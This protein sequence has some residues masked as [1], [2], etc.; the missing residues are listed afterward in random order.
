MASATGDALSGQRG[1]P[2][3]GACPALPVGC[4]PTAAVARREGKTLMRRRPSTAAGITALAALG[5]ATGI[6]LSG[7]DALAQGRPLSIE[8]DSRS[9]IQNCEGRDVV[10]R[11]NANALRFTGGCRSVTV[12][13]NGNSILAEMAPGGRIE[14]VGNDT[15]VGWVPAGGG[16]QARE[17]TVSV[18]GRDSRVE[19]AAAAAGGGAPAQPPGGPLVLEGNGQQRS[20]DC[21][22]R[23][24]VLRGERNQVTLTGGC[25]SLT[26]EGNTN[27]IRAALEPGARVV[28]RGDVVNL[29]WSQAGEGPEPTLRAEGR[30][31]NVQR[32][33]QAIAA[34][35][36]QLGR[37]ET[38]GGG[39]SLTLSG[40]VLFAFDSDQLRDEATE[41][42]SQVADVIRET[43]PRS[44]RIVGHT[45]SVGA[46]EY[47]RELSLR[48]ARSV[49]RWLEQR[50]GGQAMPAVV[51][52]GR[53]EAEPVAPNTRP[54]GRDNPEGRAQNR[55]VEIA[56]ER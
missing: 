43:R 38:P 14:I 13:G 22:G 56:L 25:R 6:A 20:F 37:R 54:D 21:S 9:D 26:V 51:V 24:V 3:P 50:V 28:V 30:Q 10:V 16:A 52:E 41:V 29:T 19:R 31:I 8:G 12:Q 15:T 46:E 5:L 1:K 47:N 18:T 23:D 2:G 4:S 45:D 7:S 17:P 49:Q 42:L 36:G 33:A 35:A 53:G 34:P 40:D 48:R 11:G 44:M 27:D 39:I 32:S 55:R